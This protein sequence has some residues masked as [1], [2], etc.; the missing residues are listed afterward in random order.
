M[1]KSSYRV[2]LT[3]ETV[4]GFRRE[5]V[6]AA[7][8]RTFRAPA[9]QV[10][11]M[12]NA[13]ESAIEN[14]L[15][16]DRA[17]QLQMQMEGLGARTR[18]ER[19]RDGSRRP[20]PKSTLR[21]PPDDDA[22]VEMMRCSACGHR[23]LSG[24][25]C[26]ECG[27]VIERRDQP[28]GDVQ[29]EVGRPRSQPGRRSAARRQ[30]GHDQSYRAATSD[31]HRRQND[32]LRNDWA[33][34][35]DPA[36][37]EEYHIGLFMGMNSSALAATCDRMI[38]GHG[39]H[40][41]PSWAGGAVFSPFLWAMFRKMWALGMVILVT[42]VLIPVVLLTWGAQDG[43]S[44][45]FTLLGIA[46]I[47]LNR[48]FW[49]LVLK[50]LYCRHTRKTIALMN[51]MAPTF[52]PDIDIAASGGTSR[53][54]VFVGLVIALVL[55]LLTWSIIDSV[56]ARLREPEPTYLPSDDIGGS[57]Y[58]PPRPAPERIFVVPQRPEQETDDD[59]V[60]SNPWV[61]TRSGL[62]SVGRQLMSW[63]ETSERPR[64]LRP[65]GIDDLQAELGLD[66][67]LLLDGWGRRLEFKADDR[68]LVLRSAGPDG[69][70]G[71][72]DDIEYRRSL[73]Q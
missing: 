47:V 24:W 42:E 7:L 27:M 69:E 45:K 26:D 19:S 3:G 46:I 1:D 65:M 55:S 41:R 48:V 66:Y 16:A 13:G 25:K 57:N 4:P 38:A 52:A 58:A 21:L 44:R 14:L 20:L 59:G 73:V 22:E 9:G 35:Y 31:I 11:R 5:D 50:W 63:I 15:D 29:G 10:L 64:D 51:R 8:A 62:R 28:A 23:Q 30:F 32:M 33:D 72:A 37:T 61:R 12:M 2:Y 60:M 53:T 43:V 70:F 18:V 54:S 67:H 39:T 40:F 6:I 68:G 36:P 56:H 71:N 17:L 34:E 49:P